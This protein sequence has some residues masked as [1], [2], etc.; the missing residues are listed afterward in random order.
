MLNSIKDGLKLSWLRTRTPYRALPLPLPPQ[1]VEWAWAKANSMV[2]RHTLRR[3]SPA[4][5]RR[6][7]W[8]A[9]AFVT[10]LPDHPRLVV[11]LKHAN[12]FLP[13]RPCRYETLACFAAQLVRGDNLVSWDT[14][15]AYHHLPLHKNVRKY[16]VFRLGARFCETQTLPFG[17]SLAPWAWT[18][19]FR[20]V[21]AALWVAGF[22]SL[23]YIDDFKAAPPRGCAV[24]P[25]GGHSGTSR[26][27]EEVGD[28]WPPGCARQGLPGGHA[29]ASAL[30]LRRRHGTGTALSDARSHG[31]G[32]QASL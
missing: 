26:G 28:F 31:Q 30:G 14:K 6:A 21:L 29:V 23:G 20:P 24:D 10:N 11:N 3:L 18:K 32:A 22:S 12:S 15:S 7:P 17:L 9:H 2:A 25:G 13:K 16:L 27:P 4:E 5:A 1:W 19:L 8:V